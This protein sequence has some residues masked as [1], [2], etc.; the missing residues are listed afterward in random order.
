MQL[1]HLADVGVARGDGDHDLHELREGPAVAP[2]LAGD[3]EA[4]QAGGAERGALLVR[5]R[6]VAVPLGGA[7]AEL[8][9]QPF[10]DPDRVVQ[11]DAGQRGAPTAVLGRSRCDAQCSGWSSRQGPFRSQGG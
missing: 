2:V 6:P 7:D 5:E 4:E 1:V 11:L 3:H 10:R 8:V 9:A